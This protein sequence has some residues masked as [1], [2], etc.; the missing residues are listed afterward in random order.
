MVVGAWD[1]VGEVKRTVDV[2]LTFVGDEG[3]LEGKSSR[4]SKVDFGRVCRV[5]DC[6]AVD[7][8]FL[9]GDG[10]RFEG[11]SSRK[12]KVDFGRVC[13][14]VVIWGLVGEGDRLGAYVE[15]RDIEGKAGFTSGVE[16]NSRLV[17]DNLGGASRSSLSDTSDPVSICLITGCLTVVLSNGGLLELVRLDG[18][19]CSSMSF[20]FAELNASLSAFFCALD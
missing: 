19:R 3:S 9:V 11:K 20:L 12:S 13:R 14:V 4:K 5:L 1:L 10:D 8:W 15:A 17:C 6:W 16:D 18:P 2:W 7:I